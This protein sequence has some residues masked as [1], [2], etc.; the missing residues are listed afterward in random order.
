MRQQ[1]QPPVADSSLAEDLAAVPLVAASAAAEYLRQLL[2]E[3]L[4]LRLL[5]PRLLSVRTLC[6]CR[7]VLS[8]IQVG[9]A[10]L[11]L[12]LVRDRIGRC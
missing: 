6:G 8:L 12:S 4:L 2:H 9:L 1:V 11:E 10:V 5:P 7:A 3:A